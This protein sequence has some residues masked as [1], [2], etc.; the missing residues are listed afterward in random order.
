[1]GG[2]SSTAVTKLSANNLRLLLAP[3]VV[4]DGFALL[5]DVALGV[6]G[7]INQA[8]SILTPGLAQLFMK[9]SCW[10]AWRSAHLKGIGKLVG[11]RVQPA[12]LDDA[13]VAELDTVWVL[14]AVLLA[15]DRGGEDGGVA[16]LIRGREAH[17]LSKAGFQPRH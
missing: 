5:E 11:G 9:I 12:G 10:A 4:A 1:M 6:G 7:S 14:R 3:V 13:A 2:K 16:D 17:P 8:S 15:L